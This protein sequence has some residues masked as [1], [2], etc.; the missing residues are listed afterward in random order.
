MLTSEKIKKYALDFG[1][2]VCG[3]ANIDRFKDE[4]LQQNPKSI[5]PSAK[6][7]IG[8][9]FSVP[10]GL[11]KAM[12]ENRQR[13]LYTS[14]GVKY[15]DEEF[16]IITL[17]RLAQIIENEGYDACVQRTVPNL[18]IK[19]D[20][21]A[22]PEIPD[23]FEMIY[24]IPVEEGK[25]A[26]DVI[27]DYKKAAVFCG[28][29]TMGLNGKVLSP[30]YGPYIRF[31]YIVTNLPLTPDPM[32]DYEL[33][34]KCG[35]CIKSC[36]GNAISNEGVDSWQC[37]VYYR[38]AHKSNPYITNDFLINHKDRDD[39]LNGK[40]H[41]NCDE[42][43]AIYNELDFLPRTQTGYVPCLCGKK[44]E[45]ECYKHLKGKGII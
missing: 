40:K 20:K 10:K 24:S 41:F 6:S 23:V 13:Y 32:L 2:S 34:D 5:L 30:K 28:L 18:K 39:I 1:A 15:I 7:V 25:P 19:G 37:S 14:I 4:P 27:L 44:C 42:A 33:C 17:Y 26:P 29:G 8:I 36:P 45:T 12:E 9:G 31:I 21:T 11:Y 38:G 35:E 16:S 43:R 22:N 3:I